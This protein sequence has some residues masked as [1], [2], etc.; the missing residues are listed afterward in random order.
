M[1][2][3]VN[4]KIIPIAFLITIGVG[5]S[6]I[7]YA[8]EEY[9]DDT[10]SI[11][12]N[13]ANNA[14]AILDE[15]LK[16]YGLGNEDIVQF[17][18]SIYQGSMAV[19]AKH[20]FTAIPFLENALSIYPRYA[21][22]YILLAGCYDEVGDFDICVKTLKKGIDAIE[23][24]RRIAYMLALTYG[25]H[26]MVNQALNQLNRI[27]ELDSTYLEAYA[28]RGKTYLILNMPDKAIRDFDVV[29]HNDANNEKVKESRAKAEKLLQRS[30]TS[31]DN[32]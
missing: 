17:K 13:P 32:K 16:E 27:I 22:V 12:T 20:Y 24:N 10:I 26:G 11:T 29:L 30:N 18:R 9:Y 28:L 3:T 6:N 1:R 2:N 4:K 23:N 19:D 14:S 8:E 21:A 7:V 31:T 15:E 5:L 25:K